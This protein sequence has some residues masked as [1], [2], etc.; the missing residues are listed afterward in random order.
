MLA[1]SRVPLPY[2]SFR[3]IIALMSQHV[4]QILGSHIKLAHAPRF[5]RAE[6][7]PLL[8]F[9]LHIYRGLTVRGIFT[10]SPLL[11]RSSHQKLSR[12]TSSI[13]DSSLSIM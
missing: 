8:I 13:D 2:V 5:V 11:A 12:A 3:S 9:E 10:A 6:K 1:A 4:P 7:L